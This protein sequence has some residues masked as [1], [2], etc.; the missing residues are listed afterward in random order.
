MESLSDTRIIDLGIRGVQSRIRGARTQTLLTHLIGRLIAIGAIVWVGVELFTLIDFGNPDLFPGG[1]LKYM[2]DALK[3]LFILIELIALIIFTAPLM[4][5]LAFSTTDAAA[6]LYGARAFLTG[7][8]FNNVQPPVG[9]DNDILFGTDPTDMFSS[10]VYIFSMDVIFPLKA[11]FRAAILMFFIILLGISLFA[12]L[13]RADM[14]SAATAFVS[15][16]FIVFYG[17]AKHLFKSNFRFSPTKNIGELFTND[18]VLIALSSYLFL[19]ISLQISYI[20]HILNPAQ[21][22]QQRVLRA[23]DRLSEFRLGI[24]GAP[25]PTPSPILTA[26]AEETEEDKKA[27]QSIGATGSSIAR[28]FGVSGMTYFLEKASDSL[29]ARPG[30]QQDKLTARLQRYHDGLVHSDSRVDEKLVGAAVTIKPLM[31][32]V[33]VL[34]S[35]FFRVL[36]M[37][38]G[39]YVILNPDVLLFVLRYPPSIYNSLEMLQPEG[40]VLLLIPIVVFIL[41]LTSLIGYIQERFSSRFEDALDPM[42]EDQEF[43]EEELPGVITEGELEPISEEDTFYE[44]LTTEFGEGEEE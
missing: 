27:G 41:L 22:R 24:T 43:M 30:G 36:I 38:G 32:I 39:L 13:L 42:L 2:L 26:E 11:I 10:F 15:I 8:L 23:L 31:T 14:R 44:Q 1:G 20:S 19:E 17:S 21:S 12:F 3:F 7:D 5:F 18:V 33:Y 35:V 29:F 9:I 34:T 40:V 16:Q 25:T 37:L 4:I 28:K 6:I